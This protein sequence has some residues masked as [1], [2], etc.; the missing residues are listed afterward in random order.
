MAYP[1]FRRRA[2]RPIRR[3]RRMRVMR[4]RIYN[5]RRTMRPLRTHAVKITVPFPYLNVSNQND[6]INALTWKPSSDIPDWSD[7]AACF[8]EF[9]LT[10]VK[11]QIVPKCNSTNPGNTDQIYTPDI[12]SAI[13]HNDDNTGFTLDDLLRYSTVRHTRSTAK[14][15][16]FIRVNTLVPT[17]SNNYSQC[18]NGWYATDLDSPSYYGLKLFIAKLTGPGAPP[19]ETITLNYDTYVTYYIKFKL[20]K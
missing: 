16:R 4:R 3:T 10:G 11:F 20:T 9:K 17:A 2:R 8:D 5:R 19:E 7:W 12:V 6:Y 13:D 18:Y 14:H 1:S 15:T